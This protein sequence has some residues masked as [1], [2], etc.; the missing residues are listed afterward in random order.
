MHACLLNSHTHTHT[1]R[2][3]NAKFI[4]IASLFLMCCVLPSACHTSSL[5]FPFFSAISGLDFCCLL[6][7]VH[8][9]GVRSAH[10][11]YQHKQCC[12][13]YAQQESY[14]SGRTQ[15]RSFFIS[16]TKTNMLSSERERERRRASTTPNNRDRDHLI[17]WFIKWFRNFCCCC[18]CCW[19]CSSLLSSLH[20][21]TT[22][23]WCSDLFFHRFSFSAWH[24]CLW[25][26]TVQVC[27]FGFGFIH[28]LSSLSLARSA[29]YMNLRSVNGTANE[30]ALCIQKRLLFYALIVA[31]VL[32]RSVRLS[33]SL[34]PL[35]HTFFSLA[36]A[37][38][39]WFWYA[40]EPFFIGQTIANE[41]EFHDDDVCAYLRM[42]G[43]LS[44]CVCGFSTTT[45]FKL[46]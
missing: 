29:F 12:F 46:Q 25:V 19:W 44:V 17:F 26:S 32:C 34:P 13:L 10:T 40:N 33:L 6:V 27:A 38:G 9:G 45:S 24:I 35:S 37:G 31:R 16:T 3:K 4:R 41:M 8:L 15:K 21:E 23:D 14:S 2:V 20:R 43:S 42:H 1:K 39:K 28:L 5:W 22:T 7:V 11:N 36:L 18:C 30:Y